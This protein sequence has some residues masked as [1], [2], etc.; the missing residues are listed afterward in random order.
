MVDGRMWW[1]DSRGGLS[2]LPH[3]CWKDRGRHRSGVGIS[4]S[5]YLHSGLAG[6]KGAMHLVWEAPK[7][8]FLEISAYFP[9][10]KLQMGL[11]YYGWPGED[12]F[13]S[14]C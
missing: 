2:S 7:G 12:A 9:S 5:S 10:L 4:H 13:P 6:R 3:P 11:G 8:P 1:L 14:K